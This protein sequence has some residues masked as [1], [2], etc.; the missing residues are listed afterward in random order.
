ML[1]KVILTSFLIALSSLHAQTIKSTWYHG[2]QDY[3]EVL[4]ISQQQKDSFSFTIDTMW[5][6][7]IGNIEGI[8]KFNANNSKAVFKDAEGC[9]LDFNFKDNSLNV[10]ASDECIGHGGLNT[11]FGGEFTQNS[12]SFYPVDIKKLKQ[13]I[14]GIKTTDELFKYLQD[15]NMLDVS[16]IKADIENGIAKDIKSIAVDV[17]KKNLFGDDKEET[18]VQVRVTLESASEYEI[19]EFS[20]YAISFFTKDNHK[21]AGNITISQDSPNAIPCIDSTK[22]KYFVFNYKEIRE[23]NEFAVIGDIYGGYC[24]GLGRG[25]NFSKSG[26]QIAREGVNKLFD[27]TTYNYTYSSPS[28]APIELEKRDLSFE[29]TFP[30]KLKVSEYIFGTYEANEDEGGG[31]HP[32]ENNVT[33]KKVSYKTFKFK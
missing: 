19:G 6:Q 4:E 8:A 7:N 23:K 14:Q 21:I 13:E 17:F 12:F 1:N 33:E 15:R 2:I 27:I 24:G 10:E 32:D 26:W 18:T 30:K 22:D 9:R 3:G 28:P 5:G 20:L 16:Q 11:Y 25:D 31:I 29:G